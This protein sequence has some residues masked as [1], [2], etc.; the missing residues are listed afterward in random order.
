MPI[1][2]PLAA[3]LVATVVL[4][5]MGTLAGDAQASVRPATTPMACNANPAGLGIHQAENI[6]HA[7]AIVPRVG[8]IC[9]VDVPFDPAAEILAVRVVK[10]PVNGTLLRA[11]RGELVYR[12]PDS[13]R[14]DTFVVA[15]RVKDGDKSDWL[16][17]EVQ[18]MPT[19]SRTPSVV[20]GGDAAAPRSQF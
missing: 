5:P 10:A 1:P 9:R 15:L 18:A 19:W 12:A 4:G 16:N 17:V 7:L 6:N 2:R 8:E 3:A 20:P 11:R 13:T 14:P